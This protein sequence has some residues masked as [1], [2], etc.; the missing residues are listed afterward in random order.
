[1]GGEGRDF[2]SGF[3]QMRARIGSAPV[4]FDQFGSG[5]IGS[6]APAAA[7]GMK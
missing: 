2:L 4:E 7:L 5:R 6:A 1:L 3:D